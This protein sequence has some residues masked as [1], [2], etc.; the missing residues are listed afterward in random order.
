LRYHGGG[1]LH[2]QPS[3]DTKQP[4]R[5]RALAVKLLF[6]RRQP[7]RN[8]CI[9]LC[10]LRKRALNSVREVVLHRFRT[11]SFFLGRTQKKGSKFT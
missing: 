3:L 2:L 1:Y 8:Q 11:M 10:N 7:R 9:Q 5:N 4:T 6:K